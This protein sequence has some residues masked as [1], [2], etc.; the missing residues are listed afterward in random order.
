VLVLTGAGVSAESGVPTFRGPGGWWRQRHF[1]ELA[2][3]VAFAREPRTVWDWYL[4]RRAAVRQCQPNAAHAALAAWSHRVREGRPP[5]GRLVT[6]NVDGLHE[7]AGHL[8]VV[9]YHGSLWRTLCSG[10]GAGRD[11]ES[12]SYPEL[13]RCGACGAPERPGVVWFGEPIPETAAGEAQDAAL[14]ADC[15]LVVGTT[16][17]VQPAAGLVSAARS[18]GAAVIEVNPDAD[19]GAGDRGAFGGLWLRATATAVVPGIVD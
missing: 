16:G 3:P 9:R 12:L 8:D 5:A 19:Y 13:P 15:V 4:E 14:R 2:T 18:R 11:D 1:S 6:Q 10:C 17:A 7:R